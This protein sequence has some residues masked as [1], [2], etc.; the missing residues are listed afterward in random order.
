MRAAARPQRTLGASGCRSPIVTRGA[1]DLDRCAECLRRD[2]LAPGATAL[3][4][5][6]L[7]LLYGRC[8]SLR[9]AHRSAR[10]R[11]DGALSSAS[12]RL[13]KSSPSGQSRGKASAGQDGWCFS[14]TGQRDRPCRNRQ[15]AES[16]ASAGRDSTASCRGSDGPGL[17]SSFEGVNRKGFPCPTFIRPGRPA[18]RRRMGADRRSSRSARR[19][20]LRFPRRRA[21]SCA[22]W[23]TVRAM[24]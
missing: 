16:P 8:G 13:V 24:G 5:R 15:D 11:S 10:D 21:S 3:C 7:R 9:A 23:P 12:I 6:A 17:C 19:A 2:R 20:A 18:L 14:Q 1:A 22:A 4:L